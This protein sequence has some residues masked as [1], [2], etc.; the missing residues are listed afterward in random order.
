MTE[1]PGANQFPV[2]DR[3]IGYVADPA[4]RGRRI[5]SSEMF[6]ASGRG[7]EC[8]DLATYVRFVGDMGRRGLIYI[9]PIPAPEIRRPAGDPVVW[10]P[11]F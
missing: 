5:R 9:D 10:V 3:V 1:W 11:P 6:E 4:R 7:F 2:Q 8:P